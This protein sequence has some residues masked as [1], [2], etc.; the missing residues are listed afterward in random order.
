MLQRYSIIDVQCPQD[1]LNV[2][3]L[4]TGVTTRAGGGA[5]VSPGA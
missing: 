3:P 1:L 2:V 4:S 5:H